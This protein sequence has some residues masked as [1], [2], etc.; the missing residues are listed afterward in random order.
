MNRI[1]I[2]IVVTRQERDEIR[3]AY[4]AAFES[5]NQEHIEY[6]R[7]RLPAVI[8]RLEKSDEDWLIKTAVVARHL[9]LLLRKDSNVPKMVRRKIVAALHYLCDPLE[10]IPD[11]VSGRGYADD[12]LVLNLCLSELQKDGIKLPELDETNLTENRQRKLF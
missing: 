8:R 10:V 9:S 3:N 7:L 5:A 1:K 12:A 2:P 11:H 4:V 6:I